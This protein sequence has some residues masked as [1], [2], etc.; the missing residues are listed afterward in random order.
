M[1]GNLI[2]SL[3][4]LLLSFRLL[5]SGLRP[6]SSAALAPDFDRAGRDDG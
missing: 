1:I 4:A 6:S 3:A 2:V 5:C